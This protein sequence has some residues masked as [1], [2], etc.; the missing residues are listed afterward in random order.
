MADL[1]DF[2]KRNLDHGHYDYFDEKLLSELDPKEY[3]ITSSDVSFELN[4][5]SFEDLS[6][7]CWF[8]FG[9]MDQDIEKVA[10]KFVSKLKKD[11]KK[12]LFVIEERITLIT[13]KA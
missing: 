10:K 1:L 6:R 7:C 2:S 4:Y 12:P 11:L 3:T 13:K 8:L 5:E 9:A